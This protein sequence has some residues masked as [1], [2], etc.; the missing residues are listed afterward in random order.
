[1]KRKQFFTRAASASAL[2]FLLLISQR[3][4]S[5]QGLEIPVTSSS[6]EALKLFRDSRDRIDNFE[7]TAAAAFLERAVTIDPDF[8]MAYLLRARIGGG[9]TA[10]R[11]N[12]DKAASLA[13]KVTPGER[14]WIL[15]VQAEAE[16]NQ[17]KLKEHL[18]QLLRGFP[19]D[20]RV[21]Q[22]AG[23]YYLNSGDARTAA[24]EFEKA[25]LLDKKFAP[26]YNALGYARSAL[27]EFAAAEEAFKTYIALLPNNANPYDS[28][29]E[30]LFK[31]GRYDESIAQYRKAMERDP[32]FVGSLAGIGN[33][34]IFKGDYAKAREAYQQ[35]LDKAPGA[36][37]KIQAL[38]LI[39]ASYLHEGKVEEALKVNEQ[40]LALAQEARDLPTIIRVYQNG[41]LILLESGRLDDA[42][43]QVETGNK[44]G[45]ESSLP[46]S[47]KDSI[48][49][50]LM[51]TQA[52][53]LA[54]RHEFDAARAQLEEARRLTAAAKK[55]SDERALNEYFALLELRQGNPGKALDYFAG[56]NQDAPYIW[57]YRAIAYEQTGDKVTAAKY[58]AKVVK[59]NQ[60]DLGYAIVRPRALAKMSN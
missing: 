40:L 47:V 24:A 39:V 41:A 5:A 52:R 51:L 46:A 48:R 34:Y 14:H 54:E 1:M 8:A 56:A 50:A 36:G 60:N 15:A 38:D 22:L 44:V 19:S 30:L 53:I 28:Y 3:S 45:V 18:D 9:F 55:P 43:K 57:Y 42:M 7:T 13:D 31:L 11:Q 26:A 49:F 20:K 23:N 17:A 10:A 35:L 37:A 6:K 21:H 32:S 33:N 29:A 2:V 25:I 59:W 12:I 4:M 16:R 58:Y 27:D